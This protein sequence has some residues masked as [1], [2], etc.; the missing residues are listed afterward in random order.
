MQYLL[1][2]WLGL[3]CQVIGFYLESLPRVKC[4]GEK[5]LLVKLGCL[6]CCGCSHSYLV[7]FF[8][9]SSSHSETKNVSILTRKEDRYSRGYYLYMGKGTKTEDNYSE[10]W[11]AAKA[12][13]SIHYSFNCGAWMS[14][15]YLITSPL[16]PPIW[17][18]RVS[19]MGFTGSVSLL[20]LVSKNGT[21]SIFIWAVLEVRVC[22]FFRKWNLRKCGSFRALGNAP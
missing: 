16:G 8:F 12:A 15:I 1:I 9:L 22:N 5:W 18:P 19:H 4:L 11:K 3:S 14:C 7:V 17:V 2:W 13:G 20:G 21:V 10:E 6:I